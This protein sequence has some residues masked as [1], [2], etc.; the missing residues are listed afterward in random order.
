MRDGA[1]VL[2]G[3][4]SPLLGLRFRTTAL[5]DMAKNLLWILFLAPTV[6]TAESNL[7]PHRVSTHLAFQIVVPSV[8]KLLGCRAV[9]GG[10]EC[11]FWTNKRELTING[12]VW[13]MQ[14]PGELT[15]LTAAHDELVLVHGL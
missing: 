2:I 14:S 11:R 9:A 12:K 8:V 10:R 5:T 6:C 7:D 1:I 4:A 3:W 15:V 13:T